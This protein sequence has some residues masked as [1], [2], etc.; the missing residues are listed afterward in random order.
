M[1]QE[2]L[3][4]LS[5]PSWEGSPWNL[6]VFYLLCSHSTDDKVC[7]HRAFPAYLYCWQTVIYLYFLTLER[8]PSGF[9]RHSKL[10]L[11]AIF[12]VEQVSLW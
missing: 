2:C 5:F 6:T 1:E 10:W 7:L 11:Q 3:K 4:E 8:V 9:K 12:G